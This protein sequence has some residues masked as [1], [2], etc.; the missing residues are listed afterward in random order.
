MVRGAG[1][2][3]EVGDVEVGE[4]CE[5]EFGGEGGECWLLEGG[6]FSCVLLF[7]WVVH[8]AFRVFMLHVYMCG[9]RECVGSECVELR[10]EG[11]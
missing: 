1:E 6:H 7:W 2:G 9:S 3:E 10:G 4:G 8:F 5:E 11:G